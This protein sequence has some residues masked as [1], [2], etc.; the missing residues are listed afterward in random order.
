MS[1]KKKGPKEPLPGKI[2]KNGSVEAMKIAIVFSLFTSEVHLKKAS[3]WF[4]K[5]IV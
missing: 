2:R 1:A 4:I 5:F 3:N